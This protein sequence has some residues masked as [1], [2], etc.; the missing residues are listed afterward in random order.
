MPILELFFST[1]TSTVY[2]GDQLLR[3]SEFEAL[4][5]HGETD[6]YGAIEDNGRETIRVQQG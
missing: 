6:T 5:E 3:D 2:E 4:L 1:N